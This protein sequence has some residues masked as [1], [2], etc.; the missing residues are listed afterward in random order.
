MIKVAVYGSLKRGLGNYLTME[1]AEGQFVSTAISDFNVVM[2]GNSYP[3]INEASNGHPMEV[4]I[5]D[6]PKGNLKVLD[7]LE[8]HPTFYKREVRSFILEDGSKI[9]AW[10]YFLQS[11]VEANYSLLEND[12]YVWR[13]V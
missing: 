11:K 12:V 13:E 4:E 10:V 1:R 9:E 2:D 6:V 8:G 3:Y 7:W 5:F